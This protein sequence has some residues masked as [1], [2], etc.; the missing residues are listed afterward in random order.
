[1]C[2]CCP[3]AQGQLL[4]GPLGHAG[5][6]L[7]HTLGACPPPVIT[8]TTGTPLCSQEKSLLILLHYFCVPSRSLRA[9]DLCPSQKLPRG[10]PLSSPSSEGGGTRPV[11]PGCARGG[12]PF[13]GLTLTP[14]PLSPPGFPAAAYGPVAA[15][16]VAAARGSGR[17]VYGTGAPRHAPVCRGR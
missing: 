17:E 1:M 7:E 9:T 2:L 13:Q 12:G 11:S 16:A 3:E 15:A 8:G 14:A 5:P 10:D 6:A 4:Q